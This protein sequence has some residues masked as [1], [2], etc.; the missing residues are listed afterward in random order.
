MSDTLIKTVTS[1]GTNKVEILKNV[2]VLLVET[3]ILSKSNSMMQD[4]EYREQK[5]SIEVYPNVLLPH[6]KASY[7]KE[8]KIVLVKNSEATMNWD[9]KKVELI[10]LLLIPEKTDEE[11]QSEIRNFMK[12]LANEEYIQKLMKRE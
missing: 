10:I 12:H 6:I 9:D 5:G 4:I 3:N 1:K 7:V 11:V 8:A 2:E